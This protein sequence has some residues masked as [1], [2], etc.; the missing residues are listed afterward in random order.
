MAI[1]VLAARWQRRRNAGW[2]LVAVFLSTCAKTDDIHE[3]AEA[4]GQ[5]CASCHLAAYTA[6][7]SPAHVGQLP[8]TCEVCHTTS[9]WRPAALPE[10]RWYVL[11][12]RHASATCAD[13]H[14]GDPPRYAGTPADCA[15]CHLPAFT[16]AMNPVHVNVL[17]QTCEMCHSK[18]TWIPATVT[19]HPWFALDGQHLTT[20]CINCHTGNPKRFAGTPDT[21]VGCH[22]VDYQR[23]TLPGHDQFPLT[24]RDCHNTGKW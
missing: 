10:H 5:A 1:R 23:S 20:P 21:C 15:G 19:E 18:N 24:C 22:L 14:T 2:L 16:T 6:S 4:R 11:E 12:G 8:Q 17:S 3:T 13:C 7:L 9:A